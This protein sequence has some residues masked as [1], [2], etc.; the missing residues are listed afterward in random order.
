MALKKAS[1]HAKLDISS[2]KNDCAVVKPEFLV[3]LQLAT[4]SEV[5][6][7]CLVR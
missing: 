2:V 4:L 5:Q 7:V 6:Y 1:I 3:L